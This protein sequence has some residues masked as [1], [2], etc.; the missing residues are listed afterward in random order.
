MEAARTIVEIE[1]GIPRQSLIREVARVFGYKR[2]GERV[3]LRVQQAIDRLYERG[4]FST[5]ENQVI[6]AHKAP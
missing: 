6:L 2:T 1:R 4:V 3:D 5:Y